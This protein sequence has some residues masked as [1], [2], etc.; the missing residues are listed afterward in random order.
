MTFGTVTD[1]LVDDTASVHHP[2]ADPMVLAHGLKMNH[3]FMPRTR[4][5]FALEVSSCLMALEVGM[6]GLPQVGKSTLFNALTGGHAETAG[7]GRAD[8][9]NIGVAPG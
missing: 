7:F 2:L 1:I 6:V 9:P 5:S 8:K 4:Q 3:Q